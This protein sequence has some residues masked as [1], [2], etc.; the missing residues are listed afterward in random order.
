MEWVSRQVREAHKQVIII[1]RRA[2]ADLLMSLCNSTEE[3]QIQRPDPFR[4]TFVTSAHWQ[5]YNVFRIKSSCALC[6]LIGIMHYAILRSSLWSPR[7]I[8]NCCARC[9]L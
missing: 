9:R 1:I 8:K 5:M 2:A 7:V 3:M 6:K 4:I